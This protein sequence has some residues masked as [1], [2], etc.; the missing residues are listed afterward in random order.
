MLNIFVQSELVKSPSSRC[1]SALSLL[2]V[3]YRAV[4]NCRYTTYLRDRELL[5]FTFFEVISTLQGKYY[6]V[7]CRENAMHADAAPTS[8]LQRGSLL[9]D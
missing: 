3:Q 1:C 2:L 4:V 6:T 5:I 8:V 7:K 9:K